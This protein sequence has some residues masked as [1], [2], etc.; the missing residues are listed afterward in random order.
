MPILP[1]GTSLQVEVLRHY[2]MKA[3]E[4]I[5]AR[6]LHPIYVGEKVVVPENTP[7]RG[8]VVELTTSRHFAHPGSISTS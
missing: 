4:T 7:L 5:E 6:I 8:R 2:P 1:S 3:G